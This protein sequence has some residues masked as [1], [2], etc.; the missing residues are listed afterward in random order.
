MRNY[1]TNIPIEIG[2][3]PQ[4]ESVLSDIMQ[5]ISEIAD[6][7][8][9]SQS[10]TEP[11]MTKAVCCLIDLKGHDILKRVQNPAF[12]CPTLTACRGGNIQKKVL[13]GDRVRKLTPT[14][15]MRLQGIPEWYII[16]LADCHIYNMCG[17]GWNIPTIEFIFSKL[18]EY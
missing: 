11:D 8:W 3:I 6:K 12:K 1:W 14:E 13:Q 18:K 5:D 17:D 4:N 10:H 15:Y 2:L 9:Y 7:Y 16:P